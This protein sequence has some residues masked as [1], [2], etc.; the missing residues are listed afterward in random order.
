[1]SIRATLTMEVTD[2]W[3]E[4]KHRLLF[5]KENCV[6][7]RSVSVEIVCKQVCF[8]SE[9]HRQ[10]RGNEGMLEACWKLGRVL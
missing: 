2:P 7:G 1:M 4:G 3:R 5:Y 9:G 10:G 8:L 6:R